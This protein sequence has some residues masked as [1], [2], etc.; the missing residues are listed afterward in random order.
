MI[1][2]G[3]DKILAI[4][5]RGMRP[6][7]VVYVSLVGKVKLSPLVVIPPETPLA[8]LE[9]R[10]LADLEVVL[11]HGGENMERTIAVADLLCQAPVENL[12]LYNPRNGQD[13]CVRFAHEN[14]I[15]EVPPCI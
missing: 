11:L 1:P 5:K 9:L 8:D 10:M 7:E 12:E 4:R 2:P 14:F 6:E 15:R 3:A 13:I